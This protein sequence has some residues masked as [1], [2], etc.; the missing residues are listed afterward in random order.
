MRSEILCRC[1][2]RDIS[3]PVHMVATTDRWILY[4]VRASF[5]DVVLSVNSRLVMTVREVGTTAVV[6][7]F[8]L[9]R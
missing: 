7:H 4:T 5:I 3:W 1:G 9:R 2:L 8:Q 6:P